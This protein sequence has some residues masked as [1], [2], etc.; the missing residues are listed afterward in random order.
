MG[1]IAVIAD[2]HSNIT[3]LEAVMNDIK[4]RNISR[5]FCLG[6]IISRGV[7]ANECINIIR[8]KCEVVLAGNCDIAYSNDKPYDS[9]NKETLDIYNWNR[10]LISSDNIS[11]LKTLPNIHEMYISGSYIRFFHSTPISPF[12]TLTTLDNISDKIKLFETHE[13]ITS[14]VIADIVIQ[15]H[16]HVQALDRFCNKT[17]INVGSVGNS[18]EII[19]EFEIKNK[20]M[21]TTQAFYT[22]LDGDIDSIE[23]KNALSYEFVRVPYDIK[24]ELNNDIYNIEKREYIKELENGIYRN[25]KKV[26][27]YHKRLDIK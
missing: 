15:A 21:E 11:Y 19:Q 3:A 4:K 1:K 26:L 12:K 9:N 8:E 14:N 17:L 18:L 13:G 10:S 16:V 7:H 23:Y 5:I 20:S 27:D 6:D 24:K 2:I 22:I 25:M